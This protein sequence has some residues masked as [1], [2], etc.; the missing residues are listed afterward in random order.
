M[1]R[2]MAARKEL[3]KND[4]SSINVNYMSQLFTFFFQ[5]N[6]LNH[7]NTDASTANQVKKLM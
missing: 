3:A 1:D 5:A 6:E 4:K 2:H 7:I